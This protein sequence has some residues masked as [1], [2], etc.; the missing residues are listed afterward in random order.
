VIAFAAAT[1]FG[2]GKTYLWPTMLGVTAEQFPRG[3]ALLISLM[4]GAGMASV[5]VAL[6][7]MGAKMDK[8]GAGA[9][10]Q[11]VAVLG[12]ILTVIFSVMYFYFKARGGYK[13][14]HL[15]TGRAIPAGE[16]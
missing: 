4:G 16:M 14:I 9:A 11:M 15:A 2:I 10:L 6:P 5:A 3:G 13:A 7:I 8:F 12:A 1:V